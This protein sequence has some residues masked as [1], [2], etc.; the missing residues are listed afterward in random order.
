MI[1]PS[2]HETLT[3]KVKRIMTKSVTTLPRD[4]SVYY[5]AKT[6]NENRIGCLV[7]IYNGQIVGILT[8]RDILRRL[9]EKCKNPKE[10]KVSE[11]MTEKVVVGKPD[12]ELAEATRLLF[13]KKVKKLPIVE[14]NKLVGL[15]TL[16]DIAR[17]ASQ[18]IQSQVASM[19]PCLECSNCG[20]ADLSV[21]FLGPG[22]RWGNKY[23]YECRT[24]GHTGKG[25]GRLRPPER[26]D[27]Y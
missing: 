4:A 14:G 25:R 3:M 10:T 2:F 20:S 22:H 18:D 26:G 17:A 11:I 23:S 13:R 9:V 12:M 5:A 7:V 6:M 27:R 8:E 16:T 21:K 24:C 1:S 19:H 15:I